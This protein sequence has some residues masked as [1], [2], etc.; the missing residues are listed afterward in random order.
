M[1]SM[2]YL[3]TALKISTNHYTTQ[4]DENALTHRGRLKMAAISHTIFS[5]AF[6]W[7]EI[8]NS[9]INFTEVCSLGSNQQYSSIGSYTGLAPFRRQ[10]IIWTNDG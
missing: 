7:M 2:T 6:S 9:E 1:S 3:L 5:N 8:V 10:V 4:I